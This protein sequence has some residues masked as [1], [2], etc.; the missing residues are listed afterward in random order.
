MGR[1]DARLQLEQLAGEMGRCTEPPEENL[2]V[3]GKRLSKETS[4]E[5]D[6]AG[7]EGLTTKT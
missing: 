3:S 7:T 5:S 6:C 4:S 1:T 2:I